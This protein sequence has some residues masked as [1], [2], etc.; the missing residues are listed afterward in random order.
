[1]SICM[2]SYIA[3]AEAYLTLNVWYTSSSTWPGQLSKPHDH[4]APFGF[5]WSKKDLFLSL[6]D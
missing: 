6:Q 5:R 2:T 1:M 4:A 3:F